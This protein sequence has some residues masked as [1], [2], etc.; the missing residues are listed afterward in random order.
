[1]VRENAEIN[2]KFTEGIPIISIFLK[3]KSIKIQILDSHAKN[4]SSYA[5]VSFD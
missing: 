4:K 3:Q 2:G 5:I 1:M